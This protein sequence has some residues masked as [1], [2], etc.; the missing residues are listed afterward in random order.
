MHHGVTV[1][2]KE[3]LL[4]GPWLIE[5]PS[6]ILVTTSKDYGTTKT[7]RVDKIVWRDLKKNYHKNGVTSERIAIAVHGQG[8][9]G[10]F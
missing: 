5:M 10:A 7:D 1:P 4:T 6:R 3:L 9:V 8:G 2:E